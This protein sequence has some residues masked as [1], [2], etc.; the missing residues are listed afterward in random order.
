MTKNNSTLTEQRDTIEI[1][2]PDGRVI[3]G[4]RGGT[5]ADFLEILPLEER[6]IIVGAIVNSELERINTAPHNGC[7]SGTHYHEKC[8]W[9]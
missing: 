4:N 7:D 5:I 8:R 2:L 9:R 6:Q 1:H 3:S